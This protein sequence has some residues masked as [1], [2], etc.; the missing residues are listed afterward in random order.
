MGFRSLK[1]TVISEGSVPAT[2]SARTSRVKSRF[3]RFSRRERIW[4]VRLHARENHLSYALS[5]L[6][7]IPPTKAI[8]IPWEI[9]EVQP[10]VRPVSSTEVPQTSPR[11]RR[12]SFLRKTRRDRTRYRDKK[13]IG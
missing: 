9:R 1:T 7:G 6:R 4:N 2:D 5:T 11:R 10:Q 13:V 12:G 8:I 3:V